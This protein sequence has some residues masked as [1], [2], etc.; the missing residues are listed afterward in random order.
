[1]KLVCFW[2]TFLPDA[3]PPALR[4]GCGVTATG[5][6]DARRL[7]NA[8]FPSR[9]LPARQIDRVFRDLDPTTVDLPDPNLMGDPD[10]RGVWYPRPEV[11]PVPFVPIEPPRK[12][13]RARA[14]T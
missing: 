7:I 2:F 11:D 14:D 10:V 4:F 12:P 3:R 13:A 6:V 1:M 5:I 8:G 9:T